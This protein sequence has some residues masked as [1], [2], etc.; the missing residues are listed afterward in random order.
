MTDWQIRQF[1]GRKVTVE[2]RYAL[3]SRCRTG[4]VEAYTGTFIGGSDAQGRYY[5]SCLGGGIFLLAAEVESIDGVRATDMLDM[6]QWL[7]LVAVTAAFCAV[8]ALAIWL[9]KGA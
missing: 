8:T 3:E 5:L 7:I 6:R 1:V 4:A 9:I 2:V